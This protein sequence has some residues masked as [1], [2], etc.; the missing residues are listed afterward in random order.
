MSFIPGHRQAAVLAAVAALLVAA[1]LFVGYRPAVPEGIDEPASADCATICGQPGFDRDSYH[2]GD[3]AR[4]RVQLDWNPAAAIPDLQSLRVRRGFPPFLY[5]ETQFTTVAA[6][7]GATGRTVVIDYELLVVGVEPG[8]PVQLEPLAVPYRAAGEGVRRIL[9]LRLPA[10]HVAGFYPADVSDTPL[11]P[12]QPALDERR[13]LRRVL[14]AIAAALLI[15]A[16]VLQLWR[17][18]HRRPDAQLSPAERLYRRLQSLKDGIE[19]PRDRL[20]A[21]VQILARA[22]ALQQGLTVREF[23]ARPGGQ[24][25]EQRSRL[26]EAH[27]LLSGIYAREAPESGR[28]ERILEY[29]EQLLLP[30]VDEK[31]L[32]REHEM[33]MLARLGRA[34]CGVAAGLLAAAASIAMLVL[35]ALPSLTLLRDVQDYNLLATTKPDAGHEPTLA[36]RYRELAER[37]RLDVVRA[38]SYY[39]AGSLLAA[40]RPGFLDRDRLRDL[41]A[42]IFRGKVTLDLLLHEAELDAEFELATLLGS[43]ARNQ[44][45]ATQALE[46]ALAAEPGHRAAARNLEIVLKTRHALARSLD[47]LLAKADVGPADRQALSQTM[48]DLRVLM[49]TALP[50]PRG[51]TDAGKDDSEYYI[52]EQ[53]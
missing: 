47:E 45:E 16:A 6:A 43:F 44:Q 40:A 24:P 3:V 26:D 48:I 31:R 38:N 34:P 27:G 35:A 53:F 36:A 29:A 13:G 8:R 18:A 22:V 12:L 51:A 11:Q 4:L 15:A 46:A 25:D 50:D 2:L 28:I 49:E 9:E 41:K 37:A 1:M 32:Q 14:A 21:A 20:Q 23:W 30:L 42:A 19:S 7:G 5:R 33:R 10:L 39:N 52:M 17:L